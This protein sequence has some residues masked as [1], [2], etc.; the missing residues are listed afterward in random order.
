MPASRH[1]VREPLGADPRRDG[2]RSPKADEADA[3]DVGTGEPL[4][5]RIRRIAEAIGRQIAREMARGIMPGDDARGA[6][7]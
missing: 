6:S 7:D 2:A 5:P 1:P 4:D 3:P